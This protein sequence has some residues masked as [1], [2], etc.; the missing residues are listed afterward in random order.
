[1]LA[2]RW[3]DRGWLLFWGIASSIW[4]LTAAERLGATFDE[5]HYLKH[6]LHA[7]RSGSYFGLLRA[8]T[9]PLPMDV[10]LL[11]VYV[12]EQVRGRPYNLQAEF[13]DVLQIAR[14]GNLVFWWMLLYFA[15]RLASRFGG[16]WAFRFAI[17]FIACDPN[18]LAHAALAT[19]DIAASACLMMFIDVYLTGR[20]GSWKWRVLLPGICYGIALL[21]KAS[22]LAFGML[23]M[24]AF[25]LARLVEQRVEIR[26]AWSKGGPIGA[27]RHLWRHTYQLRSEA[28]QIVFVGL[29]VLFVYCGSDWRPDVGGTVKWARS[30]P[31]DAWWHEPLVW[32]AWNLSI[33]P[34]A[35]QSIAYQIAHNFRGHG[36]YI[37]GEWHHRAVWYYFPLL[38]TMKLSIPVLLAFVGTLLARPRAY[39]T[40]L[41]A[42]AFVLLLFTL[43]CRVQIGI[44]LILP[45]LTV[46]LICVAVALTRSATERVR[47]RLLPVLSAALLIPMLLAWPHGLCYFN[48][49]WGGS[50]DGYRYLSDSNYDWGQGLDDLE[51]WRQAKADPAMWVWYYGTDP[52]VPGR[53]DHLPLHVLN[54][55]TEDELRKLWSGRYVAVGTSILH[56]HPAPTPTAEL[57]IRLL[58]QT[59]PAERTM[60]F[61]I[62]DFREPTRVVA[63]P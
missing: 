19:T 42:L 20:N 61:L 62:Y 21:A 35:G 7:W 8:G 14:A 22:A 29:G 59:Q 4:C 57:A 10:Q 26:E 15:G 30:T 1:M 41:G 9:M 25:E 6:G 11:P 31:A 28:T 50:D 34:N 12:A 24:I 27:S 60:T 38:M 18:F 53:A 37:I 63:K 16:R 46:L 17:P 55:P 48:Q 36:A 56:S 39:A 45:V 47:W 44:R 2:S 52:R 3:F 32:F 23:V 5:P 33:F 43:N 49:F 51:R 58:R 13:G 54:V 40:A